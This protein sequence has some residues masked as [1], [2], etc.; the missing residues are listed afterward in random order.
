MLYKHNT[1]KPVSIKMVN[2][3]DGAAKLGLT[4]ITFYQSKNAGAFSTI[5]PSFTEVGR[6]WYEFDDSHDTLGKCIISATSGSF[7][8]ECE[9]QV[10]AFDPESL[11]DANVKAVSGN[12][13][14]ADGLKNMF[15]PSFGVDAPDVYFKQFS[16]RNTDGPALAI[17]GL[18]PVS[19]IG[20]TSSG[21]NP[22]VEVTAWNTIVLQIR[23]ASGSVTF[24]LP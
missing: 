7:R 2:P 3:A 22:A 8:G 15:V 24:D 23:D 6:G 18:R 16:I 5:T 12:T 14:V 20:N 21:G 19:V 13:A 11:L 1:T 4:S 9:Y 17:E 10:V